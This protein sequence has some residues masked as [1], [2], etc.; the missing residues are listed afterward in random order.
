MHIPVVHFG[1][2]YNKYAH[3][4]SNTSI[5]NARQE[6]SGLP[7]PKVEQLERQNYLKAIE[8]KCRDLSSST[9]AAP[10]G[11]KYEA[12]SSEV[13]KYTLQVLTTGD[14]K[15][16][17]NAS[18]EKGQLEKFIKKLLE[19]NPDMA[20][21]LDLDYI[22]NSRYVEAEQGGDSL[23]IFR[24]RETSTLDCSLM[25]AQK[26]IAALNERLQ[27]MELIVNKTTEQKENQETDLY[28]DV[29]TVINKVD[30][31]RKSKIEAF[32]KKEEMGKRLDTILKKYQLAHPR[33]ELVSG[34]GAAAK[35]L[36][37]VQE[38]ADTN[39]RQIVC[40]VELDKLLGVMTKAKEAGL[41]KIVVSGTDVEIDIQNIFDDSFWENY[42][43]QIQE[44]LNDKG[45][46]LVHNMKT[47]MSVLYNIENGVASERILPGTMNEKE[48]SRDI[49][50]PYL[51]ARDDLPAE[52]AFTMLA[53]DMPRYAKGSMQGGDFVQARFLL[54]QDLKARTIF[55][56]HDTGHPDAAIDIQEGMANERSNKVFDYH[57]A[58]LLFCMRHIRFD[59]LEQLSKEPVTI[60]DFNI[61]EGNTMGPI[62]INTSTIA[63]MRVSNNPAYSSEISTIEDAL[64]KKGIPYSKN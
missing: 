28:E 3:M 26:D 32:R 27:L 33:K 17:V 18:V 25:L 42:M 15:M 50:G 59:L 31:K 58:E 1:I 19:V 7:I 34:E 46:E 54:T 22:V 12:D 21:E 30:S 23:Y 44:Q 11:C 47:Y 16:G 48:K 10:E 13:F 6:I 9:V 45:Y 8:E 49:L 63:S 43:P 52:I 5:E 61:V 14:I 55:F 41:S 64:Q 39:V 51:L 20:A 37:T 57:A 56:P 4:D 24:G 36:T 53:V 38:I 62:D 29:V 60:G 2:E 35:V 40:E